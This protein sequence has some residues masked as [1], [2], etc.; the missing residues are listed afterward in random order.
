MNK[1]VRV[2]TRFVYVFKLDYREFSITR[3]YTKTP[4][5][6]CF[7]SF[8]WFKMNALLLNCN[9][10]VYC[11]Q[12]G[13]FEMRTFRKEMFFYYKFL[14]ALLYTKK[15]CWRIFVSPF[16]VSFFV[17]SHL[18]RRQLIQP[19]RRMQLFIYGFNVLSAQLL[20]SLQQFF[21]T[22]VD[23]VVRLTQNS[24]ASSLKCTQHFNDCYFD[25]QFE[26]Q[27][28][29]WHKNVYGVPLNTIGT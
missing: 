29:L 12:F 7:T 1:M 20:V 24:I 25:R 11:T 18:K 13:L 23:S 22:L 17:D 27:I 10:S 28:H 15:C 8:I 9:S 19:K 5:Q 16:S 21:S 6:T 2:N 3:I 4:L 14:T 26:I